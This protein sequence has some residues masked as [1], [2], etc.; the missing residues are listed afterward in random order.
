[1]PEDPTLIGHVIDVSGD[2]FLVDLLNCEEGSCPAVTIGDEDVVV[3]RLG[4]YVKIKQ[5][6]LSVIG[7]VSRMKEREQVLASTSQASSNE[8]REPLAIRTLEIVP[9]GTLTQNGDFERGVS[10]YPTTGATVHALGRS[11]VSSMFKKFEHTR[12]DVG[13]LSTNGETRAYLD[14]S[15]Y[16]AGIVQSSGRQD[17]ENPG[18]SPR[19]CSAPSKS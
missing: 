5:G 13:A 16:S 18:P 1:M 9:V 4:S 6:S 8:I 10:S 17:L 11:D 14:P 15:H 12:F 2:L 7:M 3:G 19:S